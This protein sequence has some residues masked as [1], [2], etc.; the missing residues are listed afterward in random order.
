MKG[1]TELRSRHRQLRL[2][3]AGGPSFSRGDFVVSPSNRHAVELVDAWPAWPGG[4]LAL[5]GPEGC[6]KSHLARG[7]V[8]RV[9]AVVLDPQEDLRNL[10]G[11]PVLVEDADRRAPDDTLFHLFNRVESQPSLLLTARLAPSA[12][13][14]VLPDLRSRLNGLVVAAI[15]AADDQV[16]EAV[17]R[18]L[19]RDRH[20]RPTEDIYAYLLRRIERSV[21]AAKDVVSRLDEIADAQ[22]REINRA[23][24]K[25]IVEN[26]RTL[27]LFD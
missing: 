26:D 8:E 10:E 21:P 19:F 13:P 17:M 3:L 16:L 20:I 2:G 6:G 23:L 24:A 1:P 25:Q 4:Q 27:D 22:N 7:W 12:W 11:R 9:G 5:V 14:A 18:K 15:E